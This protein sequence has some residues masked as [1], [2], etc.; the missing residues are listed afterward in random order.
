MVG[1]GEVTPSLMDLLEKSPAA[2]W[3][4]GFCLSSFVDHFHKL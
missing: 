4:Q 1:Q 3:I 2:P